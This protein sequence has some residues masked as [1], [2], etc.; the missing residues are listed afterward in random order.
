MNES[1]QNTQVRALVAKAAEERD[2]ARIHA[3]ALQRMLLRERKW[4]RLYAFL[5][6][7]LAVAVFMLASS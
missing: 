3:L 5:C 1:I 7:G 2:E 4:T 6:V